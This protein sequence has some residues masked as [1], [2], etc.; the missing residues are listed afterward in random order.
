MWVVGQM[1]NVMAQ[2][3]FDEKLGIGVGV[4]WKA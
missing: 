3:G 1:V 2:A 4:D